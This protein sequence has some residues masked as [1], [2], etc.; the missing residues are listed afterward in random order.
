ME[1]I[2]SIT[3]GSY[4]TLAIDEDGDLWSWGYNEYG[5]IGNGS[6]GA[7]VCLF[8]ITRKAYSFV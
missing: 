4:H 8:L 2:V 5:Q 1:N 3:A 6:I 7:D